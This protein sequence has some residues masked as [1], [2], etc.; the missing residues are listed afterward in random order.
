MTNFFREPAEPFTFF[1]YSDF[2]LLI[3]FNLILYVLHRKKG[4]KLNKVITG[5]L[6]F[7]II[8]LISCKIELANV[9]NK[10]EIVDGF[11]VLYV[12]LKFPVWWLIGILNLYLINAYQRRKI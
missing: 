10:F 3:S 6:L 11:N 12:F 5:I 4:F 2:L 7:I 1:S 8:P 9:H